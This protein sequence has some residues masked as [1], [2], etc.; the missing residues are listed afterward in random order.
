MW[1][2]VSFEICWPLFLALTFF[3]I[4]FFSYLCDWSLV[5]VLRQAKENL[6]R[7]SN[8]PTSALSSNVLCCDLVWFKLRTLRP[9]DFMNLTFEDDFWEY[10]DESIR[11]PAACPSMSV[12]FQ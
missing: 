1:Y 7:G 10:L 8:V 11:C 5:H 12:S 6:P 9:D 4:V 2:F 3:C